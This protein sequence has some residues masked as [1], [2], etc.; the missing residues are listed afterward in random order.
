MNLNR[1][2]DYRNPDR[3]EGVPKRGLF[4]RRYLARTFGYAL[5]SL[6]AAALIFYV[7][8][9]LVDKLQPGLVLEDAVMKTVTATVNA[10]AY[11]MRTEAPVYAS[12]TSAGSATAAVEDGGKVGRGSKLA[13]VYAASSPELESRIAEID[14]QIAQLKKSGAE[15]RSIQTTTALDSAIF[16]KFLKIAADCAG[17]NCGDAVSRRTTL[18]VDLQKRAVVRGTVRDL[19]AQIRSLE[20]DR[21]ALTQQLG[22]RLGTVYAPESGYFYAEYD[23]YGEIFSA[24]RIAKLTYGDFLELLNEQPVFDTRQLS[25]GTILTDYRWYVACPMTKREAADLVDVYDCRVDF[26]AAS[27]SFTMKL[28][29]IITEGA[30]N[31]AIVILRCETVPF[32]FDFTRMQK[33]RISAVEYTG[34]ELPVTALRVVDGFQGVYVQDGVTVRFRRVNVIHE[35]GDGTV[36]C[37]GNAAENEAL[38]EEIRLANRQ[39]KGVAVYDETSFGTFYWIM[40]NDVVIVGGQDLYSGK[41]VN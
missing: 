14:A 24:E 32:N 37:T 26:L 35:S 21:Y 5:V 4:D 1:E 6:T 12:F 30:G 7:G 22:A 17:G 2:R 40:E 31:G 19:D 41:I 34:Y 8:Y 36:I 11:I 13:E 15:D 9:H 38:S 39:A 29:R 27:R 3:G 33:V 28:E 23:G 18:L 10:D 25:V 16:D 20:S